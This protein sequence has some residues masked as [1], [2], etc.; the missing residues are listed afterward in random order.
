MHESDYL[1]FQLL[2]HITFHK[3]QLC[4][5]DKLWSFNG[6]ENLVHDRSDDFVPKY[7]HEFEYKLNDDE[8]N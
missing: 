5:L 2:S 4:V 6:S 7:I 8:L 3:S 1:N